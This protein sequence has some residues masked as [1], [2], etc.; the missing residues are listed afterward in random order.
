M[1]LFIESNYI[2]SRNSITLQGLGTDLHLNFVVQA[3]DLFVVQRLMTFPS[4]AAQISR[5]S[6]ILYEMIIDRDKFY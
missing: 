2:F 4:W 6:I 1:V 3:K 5:R